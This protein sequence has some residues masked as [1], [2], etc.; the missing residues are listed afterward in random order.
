MPGIE[1]GFQ[2]NDVF[3]VAL[4]TSDTPGFT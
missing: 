4:E 3:E 2:S 1:G